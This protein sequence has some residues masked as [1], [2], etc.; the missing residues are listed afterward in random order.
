MNLPEL[1]LN[2]FE[3]IKESEFAAKSYFAG[4]C[5]RDFLLSPNVAINS[6]VDIC[7]ELR[8]G[9]IALAHYLQNLLPASK[10]VIHKRFGTA[11]LNFNNF[12]LDFVAT[13]KEQYVVGNR[14]PQIQFGTIWD[15]VLRRD[16]T[17]NA[18]LMS[19]ATGEILDL[20]GKG[21]CDLKNGLI[22]TVQNPDKCF[23]EDPL[24]MLRAVQFALRFNFNIEENTLQ[25]LQ[26]NANALRILS[27]SSIHKELNK[28]PDA[29]KD[30][31]KQLINSLGW[32]KYL[33][34]ET[35]NS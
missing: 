35:V 15:D 32:E 8:G 11:S 31:A 3:L 12:Q 4:G 18:L 2:L 28:I 34:S 30:K 22:R 21:L 24:R 27:K 14:Y 17:I 29:K 13:R 1:R 7:V 25:A 16:F 23:T 6:D 19:I 26:T 33:K 5:V 10:L 20:C 9:G